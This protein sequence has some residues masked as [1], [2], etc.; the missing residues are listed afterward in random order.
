ML[1]YFIIKTL[2]NTQSQSHKRSTDVWRCR[3]VL[4]YVRANKS[5]I[6]NSQTHALT[7]H[8]QVHSSSIST[9]LARLEVG[10][11][12]T[13]GTT[14]QTRSDN[15]KWLAIYQKWKFILLTFNIRLYSI[16]YAPN[17]W[18][19]CMRIARP[20]H[21]LLIVRCDEY[22]ASTRTRVSIS[23]LNLQELSNSFI[24]HSYF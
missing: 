12:R 21:S 17:R 10:F 19:R 9:D 20:R 15:C 23:Q 4:R 18:I 2:M 6:L 7:A 16:A 1:E 3:L 11:S 14:A 8:I 5:R 13:C 24:A 22:A